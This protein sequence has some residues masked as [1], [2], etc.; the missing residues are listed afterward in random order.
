MHSPGP[1]GLSGSGIVKGLLNQ[2]DRL[3]EREL[4]MRTEDWEVG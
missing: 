1:P 4:T 3:Q 2:S